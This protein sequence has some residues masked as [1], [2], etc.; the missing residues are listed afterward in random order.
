M[1]PAGWVVVVSAIVVEVD[2]PPI[3]VV[4]PEAVTADVPPVAVVESS[5]LVATAAPLSHG[6]VGALEE[7][8]NNPTPPSAL[9]DATATTGRRRKALLM[10]RHGSRQK[11]FDE[12]HAANRSV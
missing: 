11:R 2:A 5:G 1:N 10:V 12:V 3:D 6:E 7:P 4:A 9:S 8:T